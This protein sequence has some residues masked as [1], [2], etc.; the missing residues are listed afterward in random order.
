MNTN[1][2]LVRTLRIMRE[3]A[4][5]LMKTEDNW[6][7][8]QMFARMTTINEIIGMITNKAIFEESRTGYRRRPGTACINR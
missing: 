6:G 4:Y 5:V 3:R 1:S 7:K 8:A 2:D